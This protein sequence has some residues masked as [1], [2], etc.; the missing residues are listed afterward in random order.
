MSSDD[1]IKIIDEFNYLEWP[2]TLEEEAEERKKKEDQEAK[3]EEERKLR[4]K[5]LVKKVFNNIKY[6]YFYIVI[7]VLTMLFL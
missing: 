6:I 4:K 3:E 5:P 7:Y 2:I 1:K